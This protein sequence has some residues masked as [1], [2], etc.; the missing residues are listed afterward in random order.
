[1]VTTPAPE[2]PEYPMVRTCPFGPAPDVLQLQRDAPISRVR[3]WDG[4]TP[5]IVSRYD[6]ARAI[7]RDPRASVEAASPGYPDHSPAAHSRRKQIKTLINSDDPEHA[8]RRR[9]LITD[10]TVKKAERMRP[11]L[12]EITDELLDKMLAGPNPADFVSAVALPFPSIVISD[13]L[14]VPYEDH[15]MFQDYTTILASHTSTPEQQMASA[16]GLLEYLTELVAR[17]ERS[18]AGSGDDLASRLVDEYLRAGTMTREDIATALYGLLQ[19]GHETTAHQ[20][21]L[22]VALLLD[23][24]EHRRAVASAADARELASAVEELLRY[25]SISH[26][27]RRRAALEDIEIGGQIIRKGEGIIVAVDAANWDAEVFAEPGTLNLTRQHKSHVAFG[28]GVHQCIGQ[29]L[30]RVE[31]QIALETL[32]R[33]VPTLHL[34]IPVAELRFKQDGVVYGLEELPLGW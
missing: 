20:L 4:S 33:R 21:A 13:L 26:R 24:P 2:I 5:W 29:A 19:A 31:L 16:R 28:F 25:H 7:L 17:K 12:Q 18:P 3:L 1:M 32:F 11:R 8:W 15:E 14:G 6:D 9:S 27:G 30:A 22:S 23:Q 10:F 34:A